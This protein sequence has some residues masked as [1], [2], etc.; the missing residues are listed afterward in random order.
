MQQH[1]DGLHDQI[2]EIHFTYKWPL[3]EIGHFSRSGYGNHSMALT[4]NHAR[5]KQ[6]ET[7]YRAK[8]ETETQNDA[9]ITRILATYKSNLEQYLT[10][11]KQI[12]SLRRF[13]GPVDELEDEFQ[14]VEKALQHWLT[15]FITKDEARRDGGKRIREQYEKR[16]QFKKEHNRLE[17]VAPSPAIDCK[18]NKR[19]CLANG[20]NWIRRGGNDICGV[21]N[22]FF[23]AFNFECSD[24]SLVACK[25]CKQEEAAKA[26]GDHASDLVMGKYGDAP[27]HQYGQRGGNRQ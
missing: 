9:E 23:S 12:L 19:S 11:N 10:N 22:K 27:R 25:S 6:Q 2:H 14:K 17:N 1:L 16:N 4:D 26:K 15:A 18:T 7:E 8:R 5:R 21:C 20:Q 13:Q 24:C 3:Q